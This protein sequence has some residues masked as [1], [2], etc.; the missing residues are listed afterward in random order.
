MVRS[1]FTTG[2]CGV[3]LPEK[4]AVLKS[5]GRTEPRAGRVQQRA[6]RSRGRKNLG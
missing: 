4:P 6:R 1:A 3:G 2:E 5:F